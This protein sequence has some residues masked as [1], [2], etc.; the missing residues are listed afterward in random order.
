MCPLV[1]KNRHTRPFFR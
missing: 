1:V